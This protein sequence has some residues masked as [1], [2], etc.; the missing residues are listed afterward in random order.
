MEYD[1]VYD[2]LL[3]RRPN[4]LTRDL[5]SEE[6]DGDSNLTSLKKCISIFSIFIS[7]ISFHFLCQ[8]LAKSTGV[9]FL[10]NISKGHKEKKNLASTP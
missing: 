4:L 8:M 1:S 7:I 6:G 10:R 5:R 3:Q 9:E 2:D